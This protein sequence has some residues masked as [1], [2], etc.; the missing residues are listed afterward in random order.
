M[1][2]P[3][4]GTDGSIEVDGQVVEVMRNWSWDAEAKEAELGGFGSPWE[5]PKPTRL[6]ASGTCEGIYTTGSAGQTAIQAA[7]VARTRV[8]LN[9]DIDGS[10]TPHS[11]NAYIMKI[12]NKA[13]FDDKN[14][15]SFD[16]SQ[17]GEPIS[18]PS[19]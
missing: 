8:V 4:V 16:Y 11:I 3:T 9:F 14:D 2:E 19:H 18:L 1:A 6:K 17:W 5:L 13:V 15:W 12:N 7:F 10:A